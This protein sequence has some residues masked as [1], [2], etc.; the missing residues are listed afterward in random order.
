MA[1]PSSLQR[2]ARRA[3]LE[4][5]KAD[6]GLTDLVPAASI[7]PDGAPSWPFMLVASPR[8]LRIRAA[9]VRG[10]TVS[11]DVHAFAGPRLSGGQIVETGYDHAS[12][13]GDAIETVFANNN[14]T[15]EGGANCRIRFSDMQLL[16]DDDPDHW[17]WLS[18]LNCRVLAE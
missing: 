8:T 15:L 11:F 17:H 7:S 9:C 14:L 4:R 10:A 18:Q 5:A 16:P 13:I 1:N 6:A 12:R 3:L 2:L